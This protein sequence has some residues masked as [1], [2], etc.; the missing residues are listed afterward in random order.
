MAG[1]LA[2]R[3]RSFDQMVSCNLLENLVFVLNRE[4]LLLSIVF[5]YFDDLRGVD[6][7]GLL[8]PSHVGLPEGSLPQKLKHLEV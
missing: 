4:Q 2:E 1:V 3:E 7:L 8:L 5:R 6:V